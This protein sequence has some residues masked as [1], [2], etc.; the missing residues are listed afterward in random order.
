MLQTNH[1]ERICQGLLSL[2]KNESEWDRRRS[3]TVGLCVVQ[4]SVDLWPALL[5]VPSSEAPSGS[6]MCED[7]FAGDDAPHAVCPSIDGN[8]EMPGTMD[9]KDSH[10]RDEAQSKRRKLMDVLEIDIP[11]LK[12]WF[13]HSGD[14]SGTCKAGSASDDA[15]HVIFPSIV[16]G[17]NMPGIM[18]GMYLKDSNSKQ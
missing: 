17:Y 11:E 8:P 13:E 9:Q 3:D 10:V 14:G 6:G 4:I 2:I 15:L 12:A 16:G 1:C 18:F 7:G 5:F